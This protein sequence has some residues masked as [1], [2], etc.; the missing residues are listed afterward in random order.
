MSTVD[1]IVNEINDTFT[2]Y[3]NNKITFDKVEQLITSDNVNLVSNNNTSLLMKIFCYIFCYNNIKEKYIKIAK[4]LI[5]KGANIN[6]NNHKGHNALLW[7]ISELN[8]P[9]NIIDFDL[10][11]MLFNQKTDFTLHYF[12]K[13]VIQYISKCTRIETPMKW[14]YA[15]YEC[16]CPIDLFK[17]SLSPEE[18]NK[19]I[20]DKQNETPEIET[21][22]LNDTNSIFNSFDEIINKFDDYINNKIT[23]DEVEQ[24][25]TSDNVNLVND[26]NTSF[27]M[28]IFCY[29]YIKEK[30]IKIAKMIIQKG[31]NIN[32]NNNQGHNALLWYICELNNSDT[33]IDFDLFKMLFNQKTDF[34]LHYFDKNVIQ[35]ISKCTRIETPM[36]WYYALYKCGCPID[37]FKNSLSELHFLRLKEF[38]VDKQNETPEIETVSLNENETPEIESTKETQEIESTKETPEIEEKLEEL[39]NKKMSELNKQ[40]KLQT[41]IENHK[42]IIE[43]LSIQLKKSENCVEELYKEIDELNEKI[44]QEER[45][46]FLDKVEKELSINDLFNIIK[47]KI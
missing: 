4:M 6:Y 27:L 12:D 33:I 25:I 26:N 30:H 18:Y 8:Y 1:K 34:T 7:Y 35:Y 16:G 41:D 10:F 21:V 23:F 39:I 29:Y 46:E 22:S 24:L 14:Y 43:D 31:A 3:I 44:K 20:V 13:N 36:K 32:H 42:N 19:F 15:L 45:K 40:K 2:D 17:K 9:N 37:L 28:N 38:I 47:N 11:K 5:Q